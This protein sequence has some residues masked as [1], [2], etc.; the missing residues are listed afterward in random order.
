MST[1]IDFEEQLGFRIKTLDRKKIKLIVKNNQDLY[2]N[3]SHFVRCAVIKLLRE[4]SD[5]G[6]R[7]Y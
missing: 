5:K 4:Y 6:K 7:L 1:I 3:E 2:Y